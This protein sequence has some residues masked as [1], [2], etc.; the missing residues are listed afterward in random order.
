MTSSTPKYQFEAI[1]NKRQGKSVE[2]FKY[3]TMRKDGTWGAVRE[4][5]NRYYFK[6]TPQEVLDKWAELNH[7]KKYRLA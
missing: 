4:G 2:T 1:M 7:G 6:A 5:D 3:Q